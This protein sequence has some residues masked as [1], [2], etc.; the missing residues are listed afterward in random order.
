MPGITEV[1]AGLSD[2]ICV[3]SSSSPERLRHTLGIAG[4]YERFHPHIFSATMVA[5]GKPAP[6]LFLLAAERMGVSPPR[7]VVIEDSAPG[8][9][10][11][12]A[13]GMTAIGFTGGSHCGA[14]HARASRCCWGSDRHRCHDRH[15]AGDRRVVAAVAPTRWRGHTRAGPI[16]CR[17]TACALL[18]LVLVAPLVAGCT[19]Y[20][21]ERLDFG[22]SA[23]APTGDI[24]PEFAAFNNYDPAVNPVLATQICATPYQ[25]RQVTTGMPRRASW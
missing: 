11:A 21:P 2:K 8:V 7:C 20:I 18:T 3:A 12:V 13:A 19:P 6:D 1:L 14:G 9:E 5:R 10:A 17:L 22:T 16:C 15:A 25:P 24:P 4:F 23:A